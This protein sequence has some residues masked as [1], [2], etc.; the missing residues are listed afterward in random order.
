MMFSNLE[1][2]I[3][4]AKEDWRVNCTKY[5]MNIAWMMPRW[6]VE[7]CV[8]RV[9]SHATTGKWSNTNPDSLNYS[10]LMRRWEQNDGE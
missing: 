7:W 10:E 2:K 3:Y 6:L 9:V 5:K 1:M 4:N 8:V